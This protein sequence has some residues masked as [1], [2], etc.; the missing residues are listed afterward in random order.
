MTIAEMIKELLKNAVND[1]NSADEEI[2]KTDKV[3]V[4]ANYHRGKADGSL[5]AA[6]KL[7]TLR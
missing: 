4:L 5:W 2:A 1:N 3:T 7:L 6:D